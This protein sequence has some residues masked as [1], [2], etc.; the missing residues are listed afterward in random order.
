MEDSVASQIYPCFLPVIMK[1]FNKMIK[2]KFG[3]PIRKI[4]ILEKAFINKLENTA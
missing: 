2:N 4:I 3:F 1:S